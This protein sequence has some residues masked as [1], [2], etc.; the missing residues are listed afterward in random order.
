MLIGKAHVESNSAKRLDDNLAGLGNLRFV[1]SLVSLA[2]IS[3]LFLFW[4]VLQFLPLPTDGSRDELYRLPVILEP[5]PDLVCEK[6]AS[7][8]GFLYFLL[9]LGF[10]LLHGCLED[11]LHGVIDDARQFFLCFFIGIKLTDCQ[12]NFGSKL[13]Y[14][15]GNRHCKF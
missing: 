12:P 15:I 1:T 4:L 10:L 5:R 8:S 6:T 9:L 7:S 3:V 2:H 11:R 13:L 14:N